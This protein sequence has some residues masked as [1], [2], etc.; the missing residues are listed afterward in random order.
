MKKP[1]FSS[2]VLLLTL[3]TS[4]VAG[5]QTMSGGLKAGVNFAKVSG[6]DDDPGQRIGWTAGAFLTVGGGLVALQPEVLFSMQGSKFT[7]GTATVDYFQ[8]PVLL[9]IGSS[10]KNKAS[11]YG[12]V[13]PSFGVRIREEGWADP[14]KRSDVGITAGAGFTVSR[15]LVEARYTA[16]LTDFSE[17][18]TAYKHRV[19]SLLGGFHF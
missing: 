3:A 13:G 16:G 4:T 19:W 8:V 18:T 9:R 15:L 7:F 12:L 1:L 5:A 2:A 10:P 14:I 6:S 17:G 11:F